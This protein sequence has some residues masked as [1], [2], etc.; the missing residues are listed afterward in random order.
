MTDHASCRPSDDRSGLSF[1]P[2]RERPPYAWRRPPSRPRPRLF[3][4][5]GADDVPGRVEID[6]KTFSLEEVFKH[7]SWAATAQYAHGGRKV[8]CKFNRRQPI[9]LLPMGWLG[10]LLA[11]REAAILKR[12][13][14]VASVPEPCGPVRVDGRVLPNA[15]AHVFVAGHPLRLG[16]RVSPDFFPQLRSLLEVMHRRGVAY[17]DL[18]K[19]SNV[20]VGAD[21]RPY[22]IDFQISFCL[23]RG[24]LGRLWPLR[25]IFQMLKQSDQYHLQ[26]HVLN[27]ALW[28][29]R[30][31]DLE[32]ALR[33][34]WW[35]RL[36]RSIARPFHLL[37]R[38]LLV[39]LGVRRGKGLAT[40]EQSPEYA[41][42]F[43]RVAAGG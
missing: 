31:G 5:L 26:K 34:P 15:V 25:M 19:R 40:T 8:V 16:E 13:A 28:A 6:G 14:D 30:L 36:H 11:R 7:D 35:I 9:F 20:L 22:L 10:R 27:A 41:V 37:R 2:E 24:W 29:G 4:A 43:D 1:R 21:G 33:R 39:L 18:H 23:P 42:R 17:V 38:R 3:R 12:L 32:A